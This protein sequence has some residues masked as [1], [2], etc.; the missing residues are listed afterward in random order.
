MRKKRRIEMMTEEQLKAL[1]EYIDCVIDEK[2][3]LGN[4]LSNT[5]D[6]H[7]TRQAKENLTKVFTGHNILP[8]PLDRKWCMCME[9]E[10]VARDGFSTCSKCRGQDAYG[11][12][13]VRPPEFLK[14]IKL[15]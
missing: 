8:K 1:F 12:S 7:N 2:I 13:P 4:Q 10:S 3:N 11:G 9:L 5:M 6:Y 14:K 15:Q